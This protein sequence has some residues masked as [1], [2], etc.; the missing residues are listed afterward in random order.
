MPAERLKILKC[1]SHF[2]YKRDNAFKNGKS[3]TWGK[4]PLKN[5]IKYIA[6]KY[7]VM[8]YLPVF[9]ISISE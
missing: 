5:W 7:H 6:P 9:V 8:C 2:P 3:K 1:L 4:Q